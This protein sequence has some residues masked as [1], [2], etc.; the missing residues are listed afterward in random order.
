MNHLTTT[1]LGLTSLLCLSSAIA[2]P[3]YD[4]KV[5]LDGS[6]DFTSIQQAINSAPDDGKPYVIY[7]TN[8]IY[9]EKLNVSRPNI[10]LIGENRD[11]TVITATT[12]NGTLDENGKKYGTS[13]SRT[14]YINAANFTARSLTIENGFDFPAN[15]AKSDD[16]PTKIRGTQAVALLVST[17]ADRSQFKDVRLVSY[18]DT[19]YLRAPH[20]Y[21]DNSV[22]TGTVDFIFGE[23]T[24]LFENSQ[25]IARYRDDVAP[26]NTQGYLTAPST[27]ISSPFGLVFKDCQL[28][29]EAAVPAASYGLGRPWHPTRTF[30]DGRY[31]DPNAIGHTAFINCDVDDHIFGW[32]KMSGKDI[33]G[34]VIWFYPEDSRFWEYQNTG[35]GTADASDTTRRQLSDADAAQYTRSH[36]L[37]GWQPDVSLGPQSMLKGQ[38]IH[39][40]MTF[41]AKVRLK[42]SSGQ[43]A[44]TLTDS[45][46]YYQASIA[47]MT[48]PVLVAVDDQSGSSCLHRDTYQSVCASALVSDINNNGTTI[49][50]VNPFSDLIVSV[51]AAHEGI[52]GPALLNEMDQLPAFSAAVQ[53]QAQQNFTTAFQ[54]VAEAYGIDAQQSWDPVSYSQRY[55]PVIRKLASQVIHNRGYDTHTGLTAKTYLTD[56]AF[57]SVLAADTVAGYQVT[58][59]QLADTKQLIQSAK[60][61]IFLVGDSTVSNYDNEVYPRMGWGQAFA[62][63]VSNGRRLQVVNA[64]RSGRSSKDFI[65]ARWLSQ[66]E[67]QVR[68]HDFLLIQFGHNDEKCN[69]AK[70]GRGAVDV[71]NLCTYPNDGWGNPQYPFLAWNDSFQHSLERYLNFARRHHMHPVLITPVPRAKSIHGGNGTPITPQQHITAQNA[72]NGYQYVGNYTQTIEDTARINHVP[73]IDLQAMVIDMV[74]QTSDDEWKNIWLAVDPEQYPYYKGRS[75]SLEKPD[76]THFQQQGAQR[77]AQLVIQAIQHN[78]SLHHLARQLPRL[79]HDNF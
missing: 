15:Q 62:D 53:Q 79:S 14:V 28:S 33:H 64:A 2:A 4:T 47:G 9:H 22:I 21:V 35:A 48:P 56:L 23:G 50:N 77:I 18:Q 51:L 67:S 69:G 65:N 55:E 73:L 31:A 32:D 39:S 34:N 13:G 68:P 25:L 58:G 20:T 27:D 63:M 78:P 5:A 75:G 61:R 19:V 71:A 29:K 10:M 30:E 6:A 44:T 3:L 38:V 41:P 59:E 16:D 36:I 40:Q 42:G 74:N 54:S 1:G 49:G 76:T 11:Q 72:D 45:A 57:H 26:G 46:G 12:A 66:I 37:D 43:T 24:A 52:N 7:V 70:A 17:K 60:R 8:G